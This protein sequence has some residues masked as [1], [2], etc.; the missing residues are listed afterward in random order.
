M[1]S[2]NERVDFNAVP[3]YGGFVWLRNLINLS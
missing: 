3:K 2:I 1:N